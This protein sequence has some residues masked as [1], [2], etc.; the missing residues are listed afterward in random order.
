MCNRIVGLKNIF[1]KSKNVSVAN[2][3]LFVPKKN[4]DIN[5][6]FWKILGEC[7]VKLDLLIIHLKEVIKEK[8][9]VQQK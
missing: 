1:K 9:R 7:V 5:L 2:H 3:K 4:V 8:M 6:F